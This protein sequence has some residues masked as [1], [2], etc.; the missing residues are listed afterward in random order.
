MTLPHPFEPIPLA[1][2]L[3]VLGLGVALAAAAVPAAGDARPPVLRARAFDL[4]QVRLLDGPFQAAQRRD[5]EYLLSLDADRLLSGFR[6]EAG[7]APKGEKYGG[8]EQQGVAGQ[9]LGHYLSAVSMMYAATG[10]RR[11][12]DRADHIVSE[13]AECQA[14]NGNG[15]AGA[16][17]GG[18][19][20]FDEVKAGKVET[21][22]LQPQR[23]L[24]AVVHDAQALRR[25]DRRRPARRQ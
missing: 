11:F 2:A 7:L 23:R 1:A 14:A 4:S 10:D 9:S 13:L 5:G 20:I 16:I 17:P 25:P 6:S 21:E 19:R 12:K 22:G 3:V 8:W 24:G 15:Y 18:R